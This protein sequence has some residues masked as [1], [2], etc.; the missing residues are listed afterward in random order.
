MRNTIMILLALFSG[1]ALAG[2]LRLENSSY[3]TVAYIRDD[4]RIE[5]ASFLPLGRIVMDDDLEMLRVEDD[6]FN[7]LGY[8]DGDEFLDS[9]EEPIYEIGRN[10]RL[11]NHRFRDVFT[12]RD[13]GTVE[14]PSFSVVLYTDG[15][16]EDLK[17]RVA[18]YIIYFSDLIEE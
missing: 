11:K 7:V 6:S 12:I 4:G 16:H 13:D 14:T 10:G 15:S 9:D 18:A 1:I 2:H 8:I 17:Q 5:D 3:E